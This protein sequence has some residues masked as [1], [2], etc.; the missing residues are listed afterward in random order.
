MARIAGCKELATTALNIVIGIFINK[1]V[2]RIANGLTLKITL[3]WTYPKI[4]LMLENRIIL[5]LPLN[6]FSG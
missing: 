4:R 2:T 6:F 3:K 1:E 5:L